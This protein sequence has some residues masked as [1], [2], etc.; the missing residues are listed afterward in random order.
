MGKAT[1]SQAATNW[2]GSSSDADSINWDAPPPYELTFRA[3]DANI[4]TAIQDDGRV[5]IQ[6]E[7]RKNRFSTL[8]PLPTYEPHLEEIKE[9]ASHTYP[10]VNIVIQVVG[11]RG[12]VQ[13]FVALGQELQLVGHRVRLATHDVFKDFVHEAGLEFYPIGGDPADLMAY[14]VK[15][16]SIL[17]TM[18][19]IRAGDISRKRK[20]ICEMLEGYWRSCI[21][22]D[23][24]TGRPFVAEAII[25]NPPSF[26]HI[27]CAQ[28]LSI[29]LQLMFTMPW[30]ATRAFPHPLANINPTEADPTIT[31]FLSYG[32]VNTLTWQGLGD[33]INHWRKKSLGLEPVPL[34]VGP[35]LADSLKIPFV[36]CW[37]P[38]LVP[39]PRDWPSF[40]DVCGFFF[41]N[42]P[43]YTPDN[44]LDM[45]LRRGSKPIY[46]GFG[47]IVMQDPGKMTKVIMDAVRSSGVR[48][49]VSKGWS[50]LGTG[51]SDENILFLGDC[52]HEWL[53]QHVSA[54]FHHGGAGTTAC[55]L[56]NGRPTTIIP[57]F[58]D[59]PFWG[60]MVAAAGAGPK[61]I[62][63]K[64][65]DAWSLAEAI[66][67]CL[68]P[69]TLRA[70]QNLA[71][72]IRA[73]SGV[74]RAVDLFHR[75]LPT[76]DMSCDLIAR[77]PATWIWTK[78]KRSCKLS[79]RAASIL[80]EQKVIDSKSLKLHKSKPFQI[81]N[82][83]WDPFTATS[84]AFLDS[85]GNIGSAVGGIVQAPILEYK[86]ARV[87]DRENS[88][89]TAAGAAA[90]AIGTSFGKVGGAVAK[91]A[92][93]LPVAMADGLKGV[94]SLY[95]QK[96][97]D[98]GA[99]H[100]W[101]SGGIVGGKN[102]AYGIYDGYAGLFK[103]P[104]KGAKEGGG[105]GFAKGV[106]KGVVGFLAK[107]G[108][109]IFGVVA[110]PALGLYRSLS[111]SDMTG[112][113]RDILLAQREYGIHLAQNVPLEQTEIGQVVAAF[114]A[115]GNI[116]D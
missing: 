72:G 88:G 108:S 59:Q 57:F 68:L 105:A 81:E 36:Y 74:K 21:E 71:K 96:V 106:A 66:N 30:S 38:S 69:E 95:G 1:E 103:D 60:N 43:S 75:N 86:R 53:F 97:R 3:E 10:L 29:P 20:M 110:Y 82:R 23:P 70:A 54:V 4:S 28:A 44:E 100:D 41:R 65:L 92:I 98:H 115:R 79:H 46:I 78:G 76:D 18:A 6:F 24:S 107:P 84:S 111:G 13:P 62:D 102:F 17:P 42:P 90:M 2:G 63:H 112:T 101:K 94:P 87:I 58:G 33:V 89:Q 32:L 19:T 8:P 22:P 31:N 26:A 113:Q 55:G 7:G 50:K 93:D 39:K 35:H 64:H 34:M 45:F 11:S 67:F 114:R 27:H 52:P 9:H 47:S 116:T 37:S 104:Y 91:T 99:I 77:S 16:P 14:M 5:S 12:D 109:A 15:N 73:E 85:M 40:I 80:V 56:L 83:R 49:I 48:A 25:A 61:P 51:V